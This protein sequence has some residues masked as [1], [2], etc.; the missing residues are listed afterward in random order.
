MSKPLTNLGVFQIR[1]LCTGEE[2]PKSVNLYVAH[3]QA[4]FL[5]KLDF[6]SQEPA[7]G[8]GLDIDH[9][10]IPAEPFQTLPRRVCQ[11][12]MRLDGDGKTHVGNLGESSGKVGKKRKRDVASDER[13]PEV[14]S[15]MV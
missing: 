12:L 6:P 10:H 11:A 4:S 15:T 9:W 5:D 13:L 3:V 2:Q 7:A 8:A 1:I 14:L